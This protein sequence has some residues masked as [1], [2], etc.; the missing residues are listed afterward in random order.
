MMPIPQIAPTKSP[1]KNLRNG[2][3]ITLVC[4]QDDA[5]LDIEY[6][7]F[8]VEICRAPE[9]FTR[10]WLFKHMFDETGEVL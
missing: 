2:D 8:D 10:H 5:G 3:K 9:P 4:K 6:Q 1:V 7:A